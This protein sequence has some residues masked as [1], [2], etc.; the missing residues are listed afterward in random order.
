MLEETAMRYIVTVA[1]LI[2]SYASYAQSQSFYVHNW[3]NHSCG[4]YL[5]AVH[6][7][8]PGAGRA[9][10]NPQRGHFYD[11]HHL[12]MAWL[13]GFFTA[14]N[15]W[16]LNDDNGIRGD[17]AAIDVWIRKWC[18]QNPTKPLFH[19]AEEFLRDQRKDYLDAWSASRR[20]R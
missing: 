3:G 19:A 14:T 13:G 4:K 12:Y 9:F 18:E 2:L 11:D 16:V 6:G 1:A 20:A 5:A 15:M 7:N 17:N 8:P 10:N